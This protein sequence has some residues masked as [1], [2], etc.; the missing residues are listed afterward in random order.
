MENAVSSG[1]TL[2]LSD[3]RDR[4]RDRSPSLICQGCGTKRDL[5]RWS[6]MAN[7]GGGTETR[8]KTGSTSKAVWPAVDV[9]LL[10]RDHVA[11]L[12]LGDSEF[13]VPPG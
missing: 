13:G 7:F 12:F 11:V 6:M 2:T 9:T 3:F 4:V 5:T 10:L 1:S 8:W